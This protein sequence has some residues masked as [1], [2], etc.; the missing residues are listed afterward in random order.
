MAAAARGRLVVMS[1]R[2]ETPEQRAARKE[3]QKVRRNALFA[4]RRECA[5]A[6]RAT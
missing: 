3:A 1:K 6:T 4:L 2:N 5:C